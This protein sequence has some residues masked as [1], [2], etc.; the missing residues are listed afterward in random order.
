MKLKLFHLHEPIHLSD[1]LP[2]LENFGLRVIDESPYK[3]NCA[4]GK[5]KWVMDFTM[6]HK[7]GNDLDMEKAQALFQDAFAKVWYNQLEDDGFNRLVLSAELTGRNV[8]ILRAFAKYMRQTG[9]SFSRDYIANTLSNYPQIAGLLI[10]YFDEI[11]NPARKSRKKRLETL[12]NKI[13]EALDKVSNL[14]DDRIIRRYLDMID[15]TLRTNFYQ[16]AEDGSEKP[17]ISFKLMPEN[18]PEMPLPLP[19]YEIFVYSPKVEGVHL[20]GGRV[21][22]GGLRWSDRQEDFRTEILGLVK[23]QKVKIWRKHV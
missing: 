23:A 22:R 2:I 1:V 8:T 3:I 17:Y 11:F 19:K 18:I 21:A 15:A 7:S 6:L 12:V 10:S 14:D 20:R 5:V 16:K 9:S 4:D 13:N